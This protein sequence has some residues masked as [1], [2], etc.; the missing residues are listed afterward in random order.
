MVVFVNV[1]RVE[2]DEVSEGISTE[3]NKL[4][5]DPAAVEPLLSY[6]IQL[7]V[8][9]VVVKVSVLTC[10]SHNICGIKNKQNCK[11]QQQ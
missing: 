11:I 7:R 3:I 1:E 6:F 4:Y 5:E 10:S 8:R 2:G 9:N